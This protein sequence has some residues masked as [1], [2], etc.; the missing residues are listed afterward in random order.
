MLK[1]IINHHFNKTERNEGREFTWNVRKILV[2]IGY[3][4]IYELGT[5]R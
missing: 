1:T 2:A 4:K 3:E 5:I